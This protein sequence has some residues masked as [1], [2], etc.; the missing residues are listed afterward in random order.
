MLNGGVEIY[1]WGL[2]ERTLHSKAMVVDGRLAMIG[3]YNFNHRSIVWDT[4]N[5]AVF[6][7]QPAVEEVQKMVED[8][9]NHECVYKIDLEWLG[10]QPIVSSDFLFPMIIIGWLY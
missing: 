9:F 1:L 2:N 4:E 6:T 8:D 7:D 3:S 10:A 5:L